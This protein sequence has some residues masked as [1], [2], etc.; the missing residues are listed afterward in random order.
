MEYALLI[1]AAALSA[2]G[3]GAVVYAGVDVAWNHIA[4][5][6]ASEDI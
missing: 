3:I 6:I 1:T 4:R 5:L 2:V